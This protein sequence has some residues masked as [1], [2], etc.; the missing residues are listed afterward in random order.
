MT[1][2][3]ASGVNLDLLGTRE[4]KIYGTDTLQD[5]N[6]LLKSE[7]P[8]IAK[9]FKVPREKLEFYQTNS[10]SDLLAKISQPY[11]GIV[12]NAGAWTH[13]SLALADRLVGLQI[14][15][16]EVHV[17]NLSGREEVR[18]HSFLAAHAVG[19]VHGFGIRSY[20]V[21]LEALMGSLDGT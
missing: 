5:M 14:P 18:Q 10:E 4:P 20:L 19:V 1:I 17:S 16:V 21:G 3:I 9:Q 15:F 2:L 12:I 8:R 7:W 13:T 11:K 6:R